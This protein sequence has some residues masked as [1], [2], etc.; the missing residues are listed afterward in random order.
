MVALLGGDSEAIELQGRSLE[1]LESVNGKF[2]VNTAKA[3]VDLGVMFY[4]AAAS[5]KERRRSI[6][7]V[8]SIPRFMA[9]NVWSACINRGLREEAASY[10]EQALEISQEVCGYGQPETLSTMRS[11][12]YDYVAL[13]QYD[14]APKLNIEMLTKY[15]ALYGEEHKD[16]LKATFDLGST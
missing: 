16:I 14:K 8:P 9:L 10:H 11:L 15:Q 6:V 5:Q 2:H 3:L 13:G 12:S 1:V 4:E 7:L